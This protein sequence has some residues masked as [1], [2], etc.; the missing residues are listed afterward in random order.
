MRRHL[1]RA[2]HVLDAL[3]WRVQDYGHL[4]SGGGALCTGVSAHILLHAQCGEVLPPARL[5]WGAPMVCLGCLAPP[6]VQRATPLPESQ[7]SP[8]SYIL[9]V[10]THRKSGLSA[11]DKG[12]ILV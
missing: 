11:E 3:A 12:K 10:A 8:P 2:G 9:P 1:V 6:G 5:G 7:V 4:E